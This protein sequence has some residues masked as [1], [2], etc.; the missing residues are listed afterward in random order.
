MLPFVKGEAPR[1]PCGRA[2]SN[3]VSHLT[4]AQQ[5]MV[6]RNLGLARMAVRRTRAKW[7]TAGIEAE[8]AYM[9]GCEGLTRAA[10]LYDPGKG[11]ES[12]YL[13]KAALR[14]ILRECGQQAKPCRACANTLS[15]DAAQYTY[16]RSG[17]TVPLLDTL[18]AKEESPDTV[19]I[20]RDTMEAALSTMTRTERTC[21]Q[22]WCDGWKQCDIAKRM[23]CVPSNVNFALQQA[24][25]KFRQQWERVE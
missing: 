25:R 4:Q 6:E 19:A 18:P 13:F 5:S 2:P 21:F 23:G 7:Q 22:M 12:P 11:A 9:I 24:K 17:D 16:R 1:R 8:D 10:L 3:S 14:T 20:F 15:L